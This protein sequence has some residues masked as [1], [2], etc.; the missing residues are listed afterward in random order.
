MNIKLQDE[1]SLK[2][3]DSIFD[4]KYNEALIYQVTT[5]FL[6]NMRSG[7]K[8]Q[9][10]RSQ[11]S[12]G[13][14]KPWR[15]KGTGR[16]RAGTIRS[17][18]FRGGGVTFAAKNKVYNKKVN[19]KA[20]KIAIKSILSELLRQ[21]RLSFV[22]DLDIK[23]PKTKTALKMLSAIGA[24][25][26]SNNLLIQSQVSSNLYLGVRNIPKVNCIDVYSL[27]PIDLINAQN[28]FMEKDATILLEKRL[29]KK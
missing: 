4:A 2:L 10:T 27:N 11:V 8:A 17:P 29:D 21:G 5:S 20:Y 23:E 6:T 16:A 7:T 3:S 22:S 28:I 9:K 1:T 15:Q 12:G 26:G 25:Q 13:G 24:K 19:K 18:I 14:A